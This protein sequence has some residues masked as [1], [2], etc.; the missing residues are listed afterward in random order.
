MKLRAAASV[1][2]LAILGIVAPARAQVEAAASA[3]IR[4]LSQTAW[5]SPED[6]MLKI[7]VRLRN[8]GSSTIEAPELGWA[9]GRKIGA[10]EEYE[11]ALVEGPEFAAKADT[12]LVR[13]PLPP[14]ASAIVPITIDTTLTDAIDHDD[15]GVYALQ[16]ELRSEGEPITAVTT[17][18][19][20][21]AQEPQQRVLFSWWADVDEAVAFGPNGALI[22][23]RF[24]FEKDLET[25]GGIVAQV[26]AI[27]DLV[28]AGNDAD[29][30]PEEAPLVD[31]VVSPAALDQL[32]QAADGYRRTDGTTVPPEDPAP[33]AAADTLERL[34]QIAEDGDVRLHAMPFASPRIPSLLDSILES[35]LVEQ[36]RLGDETFERLVGE[37]PDPT[38]TRPPGLVFD[39]DSIDAMYD[40]G[41]TTV[42]GAPDSASR[43]IDPLGFAPPPAATLSTTSGGT[44]N[45]LLPDPGTQAMLTDRELLEDPVRAAQAVLGEL[46]TIWREQPVPGEEIERGLALDLPATLPSEMWGPLVRRLSRAPFLRGTHAEDLAGQIR[47]LPEPATLDA[48]SGAGFSSDYLADV[49]AADRD[50]T[51][52]A[53]MVED[54]ADEA[55]DL[56]RAVLYAEASQYVGNET[57]GRIWIDAVNAVTDPTF[58]ALAP[59]TSSV[60]T[61]TSRTG[62]IPLRMGDPGER[63][64]RVEVELVSGRVDFLDVGARTVR[65][66]SANQVITFDAEVKA[67]GRSR[68]DVF[69]RSPSGV[70]LSHSVLVVS[71]TAVNPIALIITIGAGLVLVALWSRRLLRRRSR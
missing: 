39:Q 7:V 20:H 11:N 47:P 65:L 36:W 12:E 1:F 2:L 17:A 51:A 35:H 27:A 9:L 29:A 5:T 50:V 44:V 33:V 64:V 67:A 57:S 30:D 62:R 4:L 54:P 43:P 49:F 31:V 66:D 6:P 10:R 71:S 8:D 28:A 40:R 46:A 52:F 60:L 15:S 22:G 69:V 34:R 68:I 13:D 53:A 48:R 21:I 18:A 56:R 45:I 37:S 19:I 23:S 3:T 70:T 59:D 55:A 26:E 24:E 63:V 61:F 32:A 14:G 41:T 16:L 38:V 25:G 58:E 42:L